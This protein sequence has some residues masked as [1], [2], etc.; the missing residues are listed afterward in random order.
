[1]GTVKGEG[2]KPLPETAL[3]SLGGTARS[4]GDSAVYPWYSVLC[5]LDAPAED[6]YNDVQ[7]SEMRVYVAGDPRC[8]CVPQDE[9]HHGNA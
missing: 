4:S 3:E 6:R 9:G 8:L 1:M 7:S 5:P 2:V